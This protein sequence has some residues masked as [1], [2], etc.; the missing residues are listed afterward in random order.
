[1]TKNARQKTLHASCVLI[2]TDGVLILG[3]SGS[4]KSSL[5]L[6]L[7]GLGG[8]LIADDQTTLTYHNDQII[9]TCPGTI[10]GKIEARGVGIINV[11]SEKCA[12]ISIIVHMGST[13]KERMPKNETYNLFGVDL[14]LIRS[15]PLD[16]FA[17]AVYYSVVGSLE[18]E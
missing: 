18:R 16:A 7:M 14:P 9:A 17:E 13:A 11:N 3:A 5:A 15:V 2:Q 10:K 12:Q 8:R 4:G 6:R 1:V